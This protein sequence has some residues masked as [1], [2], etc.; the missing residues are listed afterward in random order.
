MPGCSDCH[1]S[2]FLFVI[3][4]VRINRN[5]DARFEI[6][7]LLQKQARELQLPAFWGRP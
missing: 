3:S 5:E 4:V 6:A 2:P 1:F 7:A